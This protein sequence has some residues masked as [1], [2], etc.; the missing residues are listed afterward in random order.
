MLL[1][2]VGARPYFLSQYQSLLDDI[3]GKVYHWAVAD[4]TYYQQPAPR[5]EVGKAE[6]G[7]HWPCDQ[8]Y[9]G[10]D[11]DNIRYL[12]HAICF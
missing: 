4:N 3:V 9:D 7:G 11:P 8:C 12:F 10:Y 5:F 2:I 1:V 6:Y